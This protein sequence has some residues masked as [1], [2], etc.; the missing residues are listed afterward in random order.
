MDLDQSIEAM[1]NFAHAMATGI[2][3]CS[4]PATNK[5]IPEDRKIRL[6]TNITEY[7]NEHFTK[8]VQLLDS[9]FNIS[10][11]TVK[12]V[13]K[14]IVE[15]DEPFQFIFAFIRFLTNIRPAQS[16]YLYELF[17]MLT[18]RHRYSN[19]DTASKNFIH[20]LIDKKILTAKEIRNFSKNPKIMERVPQDPEVT[21]VV[22][23]FMKDDVDAFTQICSE[24]KFNPKST[25]DVNDQPHVI[26]RKS[27]IT[28][29]MLMALYGARKCFKYALMNKFPYK[30]SEKYAIA[31]GDFEI[32]HILEQHGCKFND[33][34]EVAIKYNR[35]ELCDWLLLHTKCKDVPLSFP[36]QCYNI[37]VFFFLVNNGIKKPKNDNEAKI[38]VASQGDMDLLKY[39]VEDLHAVMNEKIFNDGSTPIHYATEF[40]HFE[41]LKYLCEH[42]NPKFEARA[43][44]GCTPLL[45]ATERGFLEQVKYLIEKCHANY[46]ARDNMGYT[47][48]LLCGFFGYLDITQYLVEKVHVDTTVKDK[49]GRTTLENAE[50]AGKEDV[51][52]YLRSTPF[53]NG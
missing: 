10:E 25:F 43:N 33:C 2:D 44:N 39:Y 45:L 6:V 34:F 46:E 31:G 16:E 26:D 15:S 18:K 20:T 53:Y 1:G 23:I 17:G 41:T 28:Y 51:A 40:G 5:V 48:F 38:I 7:P 22:P 9:I 13:F 24:P 8:H 14:A 32:V 27:G 4:A 36:L 37:Q 21:R 19:I 35:N 12:S 42:C 52:R 50:M 30:G 11:K 29:M 49:Y 47:P 3:T